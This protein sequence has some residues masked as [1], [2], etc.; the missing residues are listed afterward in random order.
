MFIDSNAI[1]AGL[2]IILLGI[3]L[4]LVTDRDRHKKLG[5]RD[6][7]T[8]LLNKRG[9]SEFATQQ[10]QM[11]KRNNGYTLSLMFIDLNRFKPV[12]DTYGHAVGDEFL[13]NFAALLKSA[14]RGADI[15][16][17]WGGDEFVVMLPRADRAVAENLSKLLHRR[18]CA[19]RFNI[20]DHP[21]EVS[22]SIGVAEAAKETVDI[23]E[24]VKNAD[25]S[26]YKEKELYRMEHRC[27]A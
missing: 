21:L 8:G 7:L 14:L 27:N 18:M 12:N 24:L 9:F 10:L 4:F 22:A 11:V 2:V 5:T 1:W 3:I 16:G 20:S 26:M 19:T 25:E 15:I 23:L 13:Q 6:D 17:R